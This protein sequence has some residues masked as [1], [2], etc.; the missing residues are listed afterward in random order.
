MQQSITTTTTSVSGS[1]ITQMEQRKERKNLPLENCK[2]VTTT[3]SPKGGC[4]WA[5]HHQWRLMWCKYSL[6][7]EPVGTMAGW[8]LG[9]VRPLQRKDRLICTLDLYFEMHGY[10][11]INQL[12]LIYCLRRVRITTLKIFAFV[13][14][15]W[16]FNGVLSLVWGQCGSLCGSPDRYNSRLV[17]SARET[18]EIGVINSLTELKVSWITEPAVKIITVDLLA[19]AFLHNTLQSLPAQQIL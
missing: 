3:L 10:C 18:L 7:S 4:G 19:L 13:T 12:H 15:N 14:S 1:S 2:T 16:Q 17:L 9:H 8:D 6:V 11:G 5:G